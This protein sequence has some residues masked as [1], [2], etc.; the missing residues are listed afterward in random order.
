MDMGIV[1]AI[2]P[3][4]GGS[5]GVPRKNIKLIAGKPL[6]D[7]T[8]QAARACPL[9]TRYVINT[10]DAEIRAVAE[11]LG[12]EVQGRPE[13][14]W[15]DNTFQ[16]VD[17][18]LQWAVTDFEKREGKVDVVVLLYPTAPLR[19]AQ[20][21]TDCID[22][23]VNQGFDSALTVRED[24]SYIWRKTGADDLSVEPV[25]Y[26]PKNRGPNQL[27]GWNQWV[28]NKAVYAMTRDLLM[29][30]GCRL[31]GRI[32]HVEMNRLESIDIDTPEDFMLAEQLLINRR[33][34]SRS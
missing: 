17:R 6:V 13:E 31:G 23:V 32:G 4:R 11:S 34:T 28:E 3:A 24:R 7:Y 19:P 29:E 22:L 16:E 9:I 33:G 21:I 5:K 12:V 2:T 8:V 14:F 15:Y 10:E 1:L 18:L 30:T 20:A 26:D 27:E 25:N